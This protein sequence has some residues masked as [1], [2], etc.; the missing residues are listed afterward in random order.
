MS[1]SDTVEPS[2]IVEL[3]VRRRRGYAAETAV[4]RVG[5]E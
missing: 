1:L 2:G 3:A 5:Q 4:D